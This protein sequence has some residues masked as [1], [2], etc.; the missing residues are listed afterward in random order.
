MHSLHSLLVTANDIANDALG[1]LLAL[2]PGDEY[3]PDTSAV[4]GDL[5]TKVRQL[6]G[7]VSWIVTGLCVAGVLIVG[8]RMAVMHRRGEGGDHAAGLA[9]VVVAC[10][11]IGLAPTIVAAFV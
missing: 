2:A 11:V 5:K 1:H 6:L 3:D 8:G 4:P 10:I 7:F 9:W